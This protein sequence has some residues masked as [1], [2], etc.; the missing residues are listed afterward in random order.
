VG[1][2]TLLWPIGGFCPHWFICL[3]IN[4]LTGR[5]D[6]RSQSCLQEF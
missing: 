5:L 4:P 2:S 3:M 6:P 1:L